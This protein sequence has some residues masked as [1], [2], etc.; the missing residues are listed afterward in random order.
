MTV[1]FACARYLGKHDRQLRIRMY[2]DQS[3]CK[4]AESILCKRGTSVSRRPGDSNWL[5]CT[6][7]KSQNVRAYG[8]AFAGNNPL[9]FPNFLLGWV[10]KCRDECAPI[11]FAARRRIF[12]S[13]SQLIPSRPISRLGPDD[14]ALDDNGNVRAA[15]PDPQQGNFD[16]DELIRLNLSRRAEAYP[17]LADILRQQNQGI[18]IP[19]ARYRFQTKRQP[20]SE[21]G[22]ESSFGHPRLFRLCMSKRRG[23]GSHRVRFKISETELVL[24]GVR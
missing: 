19:P 24:P 5:P 1:F 23:V 8:I 22:I 15:W 7:Q 14:A 17:C 13:G 10:F 21:A 6:S 9:G 11:R 12:E 4:E 2:A 20:C 3:R 18:G 16:F